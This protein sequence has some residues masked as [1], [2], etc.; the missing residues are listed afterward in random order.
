MSCKRF[1]TSRARIWRKPPGTNRREATRGGPARGV[2]WVGALVLA[3][4]L[5]A[6]SSSSARTLNAVTKIAVSEQGNNTVVRLLCDSK[7]MFSV[8]KLERPPRLTI[9]LAN[10]QLARVASLVDVDSWAVSQI[11]TTQFRTSA[12]TIARVMINFRRRAHYTVRNDGQALV[13]TVMP[14]KARPIPAGDKRSAAEI[15]RARNEAK[16]ARRAASVAQKAATQARAD[17]GRLAREAEEAKL[18]AR[19]ARQLADSAKSKVAKLSKAAHR[20]NEMERRA[21]VLAQQAE[22]ARLE[23][24]R[25]KVQ[26]AAS[27]QRV[28]RLEQDA[29]RA[30]GVEADAKRLAR[31]AE[32]A[33]NAAARARKDAEA[34]QALIA[35]LRREASRARDEAKS[36]RLKADKQARALRLAQAAMQRHTRELDKARAASKRLQATLD[37]VQGEAAARR[38]KVAELTKQ[39]ATARRTASSDRANRRA[40]RQLAAVEAALNKA[41]V[42]AR[43]AELDRQRVARQLASAELRS[44]TAD[45]GRRQAEQARQQAQSARRSAEQGRKLAERRVQEETKR[46][47]AAEHARQQATKRA[48]VLAQAI[49]RVR[50]GRARVDQAARRVEQLQA[51]LKQAK[52]RELAQRDRVELADRQLRAARSRARKADQ[53]RRRL[54]VEMAAAQRARRQ[55]ASELA[56]LRTTVQQQKARASRAL[57]VVEQLRQARDAARRRVASKQGAA[58]QQARQTLATVEK[59]LASAEEAGRRARHEHGR[60]LDAVRAAS[61][62]Q[63]QLAARLITTRKR[64]ADVSS[65]LKRIE[66]KVGRAGRELDASRRQLQ[67]V[68]LR[69]QQEER[70]RGRAMVARKQ[71]EGRL[72]SAKLARRQAE[73]ARS[74]AR[75]ELKN[76]QAAL[77]K[78]RRARRAE[79]ARLARLRRPGRG[80]MLA[81][82]GGRTKLPQG[83]IAPRWDKP[84]V[85][86]HASVRNISFADKA[87]HVEVQI[88]LHGK[89]RHRVYQQ[90]DQLVLAF[91]GAQLP[92]LLQRTLDTSAF[93]GPVRSISSF[94]T[95]SD[96]VYVKVDAAGSPKH[97]LRRRGDLLVWEFDKPA[98]QFAA[99]GAKQTPAKDDRAAARTYSYKTVRVAGARTRARRSARYRRRRYFGR[100]I[101]L[102][103]KDADIHN[104]LRLLS[105][106][107]NVNIITSDDVRG[108]VTIRMRNVPWDQA[109]DV[110]LRAKGMGQVREGNL[111][112]VAPMADLEKEREAEI[113]RRKQMAQLLPLETR[114]IPLSYAEAQKV[115]PKLKYTTSPRGKLTFDE[116]T[117]MVIARDVAANLNLLEKMI[118]NLDTQTPQVMIEARIIE[119]RSNYT[120]EIGIQWGGSFAASSGTGNS[121]GLAFPN[122]IGIGGGAT[123]G[124]TPTAGLLFGQQANPNFAVNMP[125]SV[126]TG[127]GGALGL[128]LGS[129]SGA[130]N[131]NLRLSAAETKGDIRIVSAPRITTM[132]NVEASIE[133]GVQIPFSQVS[134]AGT[135]TIFK[136]AKLNLTVK[137]HVTADGSVIM[138]VS[139]ERNEPD[140]VNT[141]ARG[142]PTILKKQAKTEMLIKDGDTAV[143]GGIYTTRDGRAWS[144]VPWFA[145]IPIIGWFFKSRRDT[146]DREEVLVFITPRIINRAQSIGR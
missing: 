3:T 95:G 9:D 61:A 49:A 22:Q 132:D 6:P 42:A 4:L 84:T 131:I 27:E 110:I 30:R 54:A 114:L 66:G 82:R 69:R 123:D 43:K 120:K 12:A 104:I 16:D 119:A 108:K 20:A 137:P 10:T 62:R 106:V 128:T 47:V 5:S 135:Q 73:R 121:T 99:G 44:K 134:A 118:R 67:A 109:M 1:A 63:K 59:R 138:K 50:H 125:A 21:R 116:R 26:I 113:A 11:G 51:A 144:K 75:R 15:A 136:D 56:R 126:G 98:A 101:D 65:R 130:F 143:I 86:T 17:L 34:A 55:Q 71:E 64:L 2:V 23:A 115:L 146:S 100:R 68:A 80:R 122:Q 142:Q 79:E 90:D 105:Q 129:V 72:K 76:L 94:V 96:R 53:E 91:E 112:R 140:F 25:T 124:N 81:S 78:V 32:V 13:I 41:R 77:G 92:K 57:A 70:A 107:G 103:F 87:G 45:E 35:K 24:I 28:K 37:H 85:S 97:R 40:A 31:E 111:V 39:V 139:V 145:D 58:A 89:A 33:R 29:R 52:Q 102:D 127:G 74:D 48:A 36:Q 93:K 133:Q 8:F 18:E 117:N 60:S 141:G 46:R 88:R 14:H 7:P 38:A 83:A 19:R